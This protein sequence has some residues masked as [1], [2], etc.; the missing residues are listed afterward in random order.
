MEAKKNPY[1]IHYAGFCK[2]WDEPTEEFGEVFWDYARRTPYY[3][4]LLYRMSKHI[5][6]D[7]VYYNEKKHISLRSRILYFF[8]PDG[9]QRRDVARKMWNNVFGKSKG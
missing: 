3:E 8:L 9:S 2:P 5:A 4:T 1:I 6:D 7:T